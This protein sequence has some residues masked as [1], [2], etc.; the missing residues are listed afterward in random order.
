MVGSTVDGRWN[1]SEAIS[2]Q[3]RTGD[4]LHVLPD[5]K[6]VRSGLLPP[7]LQRRTESSTRLQT[8][9]WLPVDFAAKTIIDLALSPAPAQP[10]SQ[11]WHGEWC[12]TSMAL[13]RGSLS[14]ASPHTV[15]Q[16]KT[17]T[18]SSILD[19]LADCGIK[20]ERISPAEWV[21]RLRKG[22]QDPAI[23]PTIV[24]PLSLHPF[25]VGADPSSAM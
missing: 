15:L 18:F 25:H 9:S 12:S 19:A 22:P 11:A 21:E 4:V 6:E 14:S 7:F 10:T 13:R 8:P 17:V 16:P 1:E 2:L 24:R 3:L 23:N 5:L 20:F